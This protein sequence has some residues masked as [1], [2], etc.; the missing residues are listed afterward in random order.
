MLYTY[1]ALSRG[2]H[3]NLTASIAAIVHAAAWC[4]HGVN[5]F[6][7]G[8]A[9]GVCGSPKAGHAAEQIKATGRRWKAILKRENLFPYQATT[10]IMQAWIEA[11]DGGIWGTKMS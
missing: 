2:N 9:T 3:H 6:S 10:K 7:P 8:R 5:E 4:I 1:S 11:G